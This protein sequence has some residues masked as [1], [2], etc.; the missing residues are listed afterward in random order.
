MLSGENENRKD[1]RGDANRFGLHRSLCGFAADRDRRSPFRALSVFRKHR[2]A[3]DG[4]G[5]EA[6][7]PNGEVPRPLRSFVSLWKLPWTLLNNKHTIQLSKIK[8]RCECLTIDTACTLVK[9]LSCN[10]SNKH[11]PHPLS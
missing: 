6:V 3:R 1:A 7:R 4:H 10:A 5:R 9:D 11:Q 8:N 2:N